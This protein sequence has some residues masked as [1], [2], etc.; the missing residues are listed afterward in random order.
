MGES[1]PDWAAGV[2]WLWAGEG[3][4]LMEQGEGSPRGLVRGKARQG[5]GRV[6]LVPCKT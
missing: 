4:R 2:S 1:L 3:V 6:V 5:R